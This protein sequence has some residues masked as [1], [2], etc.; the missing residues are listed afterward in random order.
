M[1]AVAEAPTDGPEIKAAANYRSWLHELFGD[2]VAGLNSSQG[3]TRKI[4]RT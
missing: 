1:N 4:R 3:S 2:L